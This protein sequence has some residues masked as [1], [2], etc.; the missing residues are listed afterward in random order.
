M[1][2]FSPNQLSNCSSR[3]GTIVGVVWGVL[4][5]KVAPRSLILGSSHR[6]HRE[7]RKKKRGGGG[8]PHLQVA[9]AM[10]QRLMLSLSSLPHTR[11]RKKEEKMPQPPLPGAIAT[12]VAIVTKPTPLARIAFNQ[13]ICVIS[14]LSRRLWLE[15]RKKKKFFSFTL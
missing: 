3:V 14:C 2:Q 6:R 10:S 12:I 8:V 11:E 9:T 7:G 1:E 15:I 13:T 5:Y 4:G